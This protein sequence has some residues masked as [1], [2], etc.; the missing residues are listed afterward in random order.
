MSSS[1]LGGGFGPGSDFRF[2]GF[3]N[4]ASDGRSSN[5]RYPSAWW[6]VA[7]M[8]MPSTVKSLFRWCRYHALA[9][10][11]IS[12]VV[13][14]M[15][16][17]PITKIIIDSDEL[18]GFG[19]QRDR[20]DDLF[21]NVLDLHRF[22]V[23]ANLDKET[24]G[25]CLVSIVYPFHKYLACRSCGYK[26]RITRLK[27]RL[28]WDFSNWEYTLRCPRCEHNGP[29]EVDDR[30]SHSYRDIRLI[31]WNPTD[32][33][34]EFN[35]ITQRSR[36]YYSI[37][38]RIR[39]K[40]LVKDQA[41]LE[42]MP[43][44]FIRAMK[45][46]RPI[47]LTD[48]NLYHFKAPTVSVA[49]ND[50]GWAYPPILPALKDSFYLQ[51]LKKSNEAIMLEHLIPLDILFPSTQDPNASPYTM[52]NLSDWKRN[53]EVELQKWRWDPNH[54]P[55]MPLPVGVTRI[56]GNGRALMPTQ[57]IRVWAEHIIAGMGAPQEFAFGGMSW[58]GSSVTL[59][60]LENRFL[61]GREEHHR[62]LNH[63]LIPN[64]AR[65]MGWRAIKVHMKAFKMAD[66]LQSKQM[67]LS[68]NQLKKVSDRTLLA[69]FDKDPLDEMRTI[70]K[71]LRRN[72]EVAKL[73]ALY[74]AEIQGEAQQIQTKFQLKAQKTM[75]EQQQEMQQG[76][77]GVPEPQA[78]GMQMGQPVQ[79]SG[80]E[81]GGG[82]QTVDIIEYAEA[83]ARRLMSTEE[84]ERSE[85]LNRMNQQSPRLA[86]LV[87]Q[88]LATATALEQKPLP[89]QRPPRRA[90]GAGI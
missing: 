11:L 12:S 31:R 23:N 67:L 30:W 3:R 8:D 7:H 10:P 13:R 76:A 74:K 75:M 34:I 51:V 35:P 57:E 86:Q 85:L 26:A 82:G 27:F 40:V 1:S 63:F 81:G 87:Q 49:D 33:N 43:H 18:E 2:S 48:S 21:H 44:A 6:D 80:G 32:I 71:E 46:A 42:E 9:N 4:G 83:L 52:V 47:R 68:L 77:G 84:P 29:C 56:G 89:E 70:E 90:G 69:E 28:E 22:Q 72:L 15:A 25:N 66:D 19:H 79:Q 5:F 24:Y 88:K 65:F 20:W 73:D 14:K 53:V 45:T 58:T 78:P 60:M 37:P 41:Y 50:A 62:F 55:I 38:A 39:K 54:K 61:N 64:I 17:Y 36:Y 16:E 59:R